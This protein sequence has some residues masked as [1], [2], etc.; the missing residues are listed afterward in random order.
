MEIN[1]D[2]IN[3]YISGK[4]I[5]KLVVEYGI[6]DHFIDK[7]LKQAGVTKRP[8]TVSRDVVLKMID[9]YKNGDSALKIGARYGVSDTSVFRTLKKN[10]VNIRALKYA[11]RHFPI[12]EHFFDNIDC[13]EKA[14]AF[15][16]LF[17]DGCKRDGENCV[18]ITLK[19]DDHDI[20]QHVSELI[21]P[22]A[23]V[24]F[25]D[26]SNCKD[27][28]NRRSQYKIELWNDII[29]NTLVSYGLIPRKS[30][31]K[32]FPEVILNSNEDIIRW[33]IRGYFDGNGSIFCVYT[34]INIRS[35]RVSI[36]S[37]LEMCHTMEDI[38]I[39]YI[40]SHDFTIT[41]RHEV[42]N[43]DMSCST[44]EGSLKFCN[45]LYKDATIFM[46][47]KYFKYRALVYRIGENNDKSI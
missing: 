29:S 9:E 5:R 40:N 16:L 34:G 10:G 30:L 6:S 31:V 39:K 45:W 14:Y 37:T 42:N 12:D 18:A 20:L 23:T 21:Q 38:F 41:T 28:A 47:R 32:Q 3:E 36:S 8:K 4:S 46:P 19:E 35:A 24:R 2:L 15:G 13:E 43:F 7:M 25:C 33:F 27:S 11:K 44:I 26:R 22:G 17:A 1:Q